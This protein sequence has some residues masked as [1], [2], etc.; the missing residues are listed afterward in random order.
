[1]IGKAEVTGDFSFTGKYIWG[2]HSYVSFLIASHS[3]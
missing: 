1:M 2:T 3:R